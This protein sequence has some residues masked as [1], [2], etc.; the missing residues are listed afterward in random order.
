MSDIHTAYNEAEKLIDSGDLTTAAEKL[1]ALLQQDDSFIL[2]HL[3]LARVSTRLGNHETAITH[4]RRAC[5]LEPN[6]AFNFTALSI[7]YQ[8]A[9]A[10]TGDPQ[11][12]Q[13]AEEARD[14]AHRLH[15]V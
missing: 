13:L 8:R 1:T 11:F 2:G 9:W 12:I 7:T 14:V 6:E 3:A 5:E 10:G 4:A 15:H